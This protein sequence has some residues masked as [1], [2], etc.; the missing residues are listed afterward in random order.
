VE[1]Y[2]IDDGGPGYHYRNTYTATQ[3]N[4]A[5][6]IAF[7][8]LTFSSTESLLVKDN[9]FRQSATTYPAQF[10]IATNEGSIIGSGGTNRLTEAEADA[11]WGATGTFTGNVNSTDVVFDVDGRMQGVFATYRGL[12]GAYIE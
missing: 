2:G 7:A 1:R 3:F 4:K 6:Y 11:G 12:K 10:T 9:A 8:K 5:T